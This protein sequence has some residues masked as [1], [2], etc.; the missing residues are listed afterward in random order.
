MIWVSDPLHPQSLQE[1]WGCQLPHQVNRHGIGLKDDIN[2]EV[3][4]FKPHIQTTKGQSKI[5][6]LKSSTCM[7]TFLFSLFQFQVT[8][9]LKSDSVL[10]RRAGQVK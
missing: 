4:D 5:K 1:E 3:T 6:A 9:T 2:A 10:Q 7:M 8:K